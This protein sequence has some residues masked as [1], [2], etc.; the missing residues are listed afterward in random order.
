MQLSHGSFSTDP[1]MM[2]HVT[3]LYTLFYCPKTTQLQSQMKIKLTD[4]PF[5]LNQLWLPFLSNEGNM[6][7]WAKKCCNRPRSPL[8]IGLGVVVNCQRRVGLL[9]P[10]DCHHPRFI[11]AHVMILKDWCYVLETPCV[12]YNSSY[13]HFI[14]LAKNPHHNRICAN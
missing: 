4:D 8:Y 12:W 2:Q 11:F 14:S 9:G 7:N 6:I 5:R 10:G 1:V 13:S 3:T